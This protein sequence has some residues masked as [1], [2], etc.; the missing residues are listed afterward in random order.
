MSPQKSPICTFYLL[1]MGMLQ[2]S[3]RYQV[4]TPTA[5]TVIQIISNFASCLA[6]FSN[7]KTS[8]NDENRTCDRTT[9]SPCLSKTELIQSH[10]MPVTL[11]QN[12]C[13]LFQPCRLLR[14]I[15]STIAMRVTPRTISLHR[16]QHVASP[17]HQLQN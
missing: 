8:S 4:A 15:S 5:G 12:T 6:Y 13:I 3:P 1:L 10:I 11:L 2:Q 7:S 16:E 9:S 17:F 14:K